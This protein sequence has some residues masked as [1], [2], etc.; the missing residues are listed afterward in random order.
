[1]RKV[2]TSHVGVV[3]MLGLMVSFGASKVT[4]CF[5]ITITKGPADA[6]PPSLC[7]GPAEVTGRPVHLQLLDED[8]I[9]RITKVH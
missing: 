8:H 7:I 6:L 4:V 1:M 2:L 3:A 9:F 5:D